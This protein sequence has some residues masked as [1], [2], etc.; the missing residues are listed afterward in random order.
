[1][2][3][4]LPSCST[5]NSNCSRMEG[6]IQARTCAVRFSRLM[7]KMPPA[8]GVQAG[9]EDPQG[10]SRRR[11]LAGGGKSYPLSRGL[12]CCCLAPEDVR[13]NY[14]TRNAKLF[15]VSNGHFRADL[16]VAVLVTANGGL[17]NA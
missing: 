15:F 7:K 14:F 13:T 8:K 12:S 6:G 10:E 2:E 5:N 16:A 1:M 11:S 9:G 3:T 17:M 4:T